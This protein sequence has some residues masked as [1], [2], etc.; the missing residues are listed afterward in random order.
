[1]VEPP[2]SPHAGDFGPGKRFRVGKTAKQGDIHHIS[3]RL[4][5]SENRQFPHM[6]G[7]SPLTPEAALGQALRKLRLAAG[8]SQ[9]RLGHESGVQRNFI[10][11]I[12]T[13]QSQPTVTTLFKLAN[14]LGVRASKLIALTEG[15][16]D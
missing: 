13:G 5:L 12:E 1:M 4:S 3:G 14:A 10:S 6:P 7:N 2:G 11:L 9:E 15:L 8:W 16:L